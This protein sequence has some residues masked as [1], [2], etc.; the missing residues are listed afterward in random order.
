MA[1]T[2]EGG[3]GGALHQSG[4]RARRP[5]GAIGFQ[6]AALSRACPQDRAQAANLGVDTWQ[7]AGRNVCHYLWRI[8]TSSGAAGRL[9]GR[10]CPETAGIRTSPRRTRTSAGPASR[11]RGELE[12]FGRPD[13][14]GASALWGG[15]ARLSSRKAPPS[16]AHKKTR[17]PFS[18]P[19][20]SRHGESP[21]T[22]PES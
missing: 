7:L 21:R 19:A 13:G 12:L 18:G 16:P 6:P 17:A 14:R 15:R 1:Q 5:G 8:V 3:G 4:G 10:S 9:V 22:R 11:R 2:I 20:A